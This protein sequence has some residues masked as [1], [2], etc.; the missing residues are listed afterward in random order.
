MIFF[1]ASI[2]KYRLDI[3]K[4]GL[5]WGCKMHTKGISKLHTAYSPTLSLLAILLLIFLQ[6]PLSILPARGEEIKGEWIEGEGIAQIGEQDEI[7]A[8]EAWARA[9]ND[10]R[11]QVLEKATGVAIHGSTFIYNDELIHDLVQAAT[12]GIITEEKVIDKKVQPSEM[13]TSTGEILITTLYTLKIRAKV[14]P[15]QM[16]RR[17]NFNVKASLLRPGHSQEMKKPVFQEKEETII[18]VTVNQ[19]AYLSLFSVSQNGVV[20]RLV[21]N[22]FLSMPKVSPDQEFIFPD[23]QL[24]TLGIKMKPILPKGKE[25]AVESILVVATKEKQEFLKERFKKSEQG[26]EETE[27]IT[28]MELLKEIANLD[29]SSW[30]EATVGYEIRK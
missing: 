12:R 20:S 19:D 2:L 10:A 26:S 24:R 18:R 1:F 22:P 25:K 23:N 3:F 15:I 17:G 21:P 27:P 7:T 4:E 6:W 30:A 11:R 16:E 14:K 8:A 29:I 28:L 9:H 13:K 5:F